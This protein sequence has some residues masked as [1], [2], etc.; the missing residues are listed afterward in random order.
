[1]RRKK[2]L[3]V[4]H[5]PPPIHGVS[6]MNAILK[7]SALLNNTLDCGFINLSLASGADDFRKHRLKKYIDSV[8]VVIK[9]FFYLLF[10]RPHTVYI[11]PFPFGI[12]F[13]KDAL[14]IL[15]CKAFKKHV[16]LHLHTHG[17]KSAA[18]GS[19]KTW[20]YRRVFKSTQVIC[21]SPRLT[22]DIEG[23]Y[24]GKVYIVPNGIPVVNSTLQ[25]TVKSGEL[26]IVFLSN[27]ISGK[28]VMLVLDAFKSII[29]RGLYHQLI[30]AGADADIKAETL[31][32]YVKKHQLESYVNIIGP[33]YGAAKWHVLQTADMLVLPSNYDT[34]GLVLLEAMQFGVPCI[35][36]NFG[37]IP[38]VL[39]SNRGLL[40]P[41]LTVEAVAEAILDLC[42]HPEKRLQM[43]REAFAYYHQEYTSERFEQ[44]CLQVLQENPDCIVSL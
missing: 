19:F 4:V 26:K 28:G 18:R 8:V 31:K 36:S 3:F 13:Y 10:K 32:A 37:G 17:F 12:A 24:Q 33:V 43:S 42:N 5:L 39:G 29:E 14:I 15:I 16:V 21:L 2:I 11:T 35:A 40:L 1:M 20:F 7:N 44:R 23:L 6:V 22:E 30:I 25:Y 38:D 34:F 41:A 9:T 27:L